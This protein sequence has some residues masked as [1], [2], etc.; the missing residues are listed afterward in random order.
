MNHIATG[1]AMRLGENYSLLIIGDSNG[2][3]DGSGGN[4]PSCQDAGTETSIP[5]NWSLMVA[6]LWNF[7]WMET[8]RFR[9]FM[10]EGFYRRKG[11]SE[12]G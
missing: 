7:S 6:A 1:R 8:D 9:V 5:R 11:G 10:S 3:G 4:S 2:D 12:G